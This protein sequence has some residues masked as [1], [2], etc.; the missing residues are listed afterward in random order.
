MSK[1]I[2][3]VLLCLPLVA[4]LAVA[5]PSAVRADP[6]DQTDY[7]AVWQYAEAPPQPDPADGYTAYWQEVQDKQLANQGQ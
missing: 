4:A 7:N 6:P 5:A 2:R 1:I 3:R